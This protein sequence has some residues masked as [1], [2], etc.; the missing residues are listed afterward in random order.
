MHVL[1]FFFLSFYFPGIL[2]IL[3][4]GKSLFLQSG[5]KRPHSLVKCVSRGNLAMDSLLTLCWPC[6]YSS[7]IFVGLDVH[8]HTSP[9]ACVAGHCKRWGGGSIHPNQQ[10]LWFAGVTWKGSPEHP[11]PASC[12]GKLFPLLHQN[13]HRRWHLDGS[14]GAGVM[15]GTQTS[16][17]P[18]FDLSLNVVPWTWSLRGWLYRMWLNGGKP[19]AYLCLF[20]FRCCNLPSSRVS[21]FY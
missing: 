2:N 6:V 20:V 11:G 19:G 18:R 14:F 1:F 9:I 7:C 13:L 5:K 16:L 21:L 4:V 17:V 15:E 12:W 3:T 10:V 8:T